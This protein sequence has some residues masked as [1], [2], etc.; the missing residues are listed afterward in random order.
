MTPAPHAHIEAADPRQAQ[1]LDFDEGAWTRMVALLDAYS[2]ICDGQLN[3]PDDGIP[4]VQL[5]RGSDELGGLIGPPALLVA[6]E[7]HAMDMRPFAE[8]HRHAMSLVAR[9]TDG[10]VH[11]PLA[12]RLQ[13]MHGTRDRDSLHDLIACMMDAA[14]GQGLRVQIRRPSAPETQ[15]ER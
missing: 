10:I 4:S 8:V 12:R 3:Y 11:A 14:D 5:L 6:L 13:A 7:A 2:M 15:A 9:D 1:M